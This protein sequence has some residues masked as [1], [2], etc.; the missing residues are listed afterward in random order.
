VKEP[1]KI[2]LISMSLHSPENNDRERLARS[3][4]TLAAE[5]A[6]GEDQTIT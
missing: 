3:E 2:F 6:E 4:M 1:K 5:R